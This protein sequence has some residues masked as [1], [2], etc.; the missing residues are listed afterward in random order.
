MTDRVDIDNNGRISSPIMVVAR[1]TAGGQVFASAL[2]MQCSWLA[3]G[4]SGIVLGIPVA[5]CVVRILLP[6]WAAIRLMFVGRG[7]NLRRASAY[8]GRERASARG[9]SRTARWK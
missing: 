8:S 4:A 5:V 2:H 1:T 3:G 6:V 7:S 9:D